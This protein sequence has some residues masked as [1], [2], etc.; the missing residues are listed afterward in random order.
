MKAPD[1]THSPALPMEIHAPG[2][3][4]QRLNAHLMAFTFFCIGAVAAWCK[5]WES[6]SMQEVGCLLAIIWFPSVLVESFRRFEIEN[7]GWAAA[8][9][10]GIAGYDGVCRLLHPGYGMGC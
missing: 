8:F 3:S 1:H 6:P 10:S 9:L 4:S 5:A 2:D 7:Y